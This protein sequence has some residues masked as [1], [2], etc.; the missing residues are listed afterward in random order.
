MLDSTVFD[1]N[2]L[3]VTNFPKS[4]YSLKDLITQI[5]LSCLDTTKI[6]YM[7]SMFKT[8][9]NIISL[10]LRT[11]NTENV[12]YM[13]SMF[14]SLNNLTS[15]DLSSFNTENVISMYCMFEYDS[16]LTSLDLSSFNTKNVVSMEF[17]FSSCSRLSSLNL[18]NFNTS[19]VKTMFNMFA[20]CKNLSTLTLGPDWGINTSI[21][22]FDLSYSPLTHDSCL[23]VFNK[24]ADKTQTA[25]TSATLKLSSTTKALMSDDE[26]AIA[27]AKGWTVS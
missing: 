4:D 9:N 25:T 20:G 7:G 14:W 23:D 19:S 2:T 1:G 16:K 13:G 22:S 12:T 26:I 17:M 21:S 27:T 24:L 10:D 8:M 5:D 6:T 11:F 15:L 18:C 3:I